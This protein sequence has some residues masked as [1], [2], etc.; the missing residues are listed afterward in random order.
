MN[1]ITKNRQCKRNLVKIV[2]SAFGGKEVLLSYTEFPD[3]FWDDSF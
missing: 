1:T 3:G 2:E